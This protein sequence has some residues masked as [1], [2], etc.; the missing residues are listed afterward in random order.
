MPKA[1]GDV[2]AAKKAALDA[3]YDIG[4]KPHSPLL[5]ASRMAAM[6]R[7]DVFAESAVITRIETNFHYQAVTLSTQGDCSGA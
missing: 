3:E 6:Q 2:E 5:A 7:L 1:L 4:G